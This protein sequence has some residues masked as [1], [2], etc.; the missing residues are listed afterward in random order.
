MKRFL[1]P[2][3]GILMLAGLV[4]AGNSSNQAQAAATCTTDGAIQ[5]SASGGPPATASAWW[6]ALPEPEPKCET[7]IRVEIW[8]S[9]NVKKASGWIK[10]TQANLGKLTTATES[11]ALSH[12]RVES[13]FLTPGAV[14]GCKTIYPTVGTWHQCTNIKTVRLSLAG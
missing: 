2:L 8:N 10:S 3:F 7:E 5:F 9:S 4:L 1:I 12:A 6:T 11:G 14:R 13:Q